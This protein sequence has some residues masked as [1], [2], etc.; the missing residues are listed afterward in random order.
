MRLAELQDEVDVP[1]IYDIIRKKL[2]AGEKIMVIDDLEYQNRAHKIDIQHMGETPYVVLSYASI[3]ASSN[4]W[5]LAWPASSINE[6]HYL[7]D[8]TLTKKDGYWELKV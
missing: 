5:S 8:W 4:D 3:P 2:A 1:I 6:F 7:D